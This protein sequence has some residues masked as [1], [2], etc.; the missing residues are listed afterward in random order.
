MNEIRR[1]MS[2][3]AAGEALTV[4]PEL[5]PSEL[6]IAR[7]RLRQRWELASVL[8]FLNV[9]EPVIESKMKTSAGDIEAALIKPDKLLSQ[10][11]IMLLKG[12]PPVSKSLKSSD[13]WVKELCKKLAKWWP[14]VAEGDNPLTAAKGEENSRY[15]ELDPTIRLSILKALCEIRAAQDDVV[16]YIND[17][18]KSGTELSYFRKDKIGGDGNRTAYWY[19]GNTIIG[20]RLYKEVNKYESNQKVKGKGTVPVMSSHWKTLATNLEEFH[21]VVDDFSSSED[22]VEVFVSKIIET[23]AIPVLE[24]L[25]KKK[26]KALRQQE[27]Q[28]TLLNGFRNSGITRSCRNRR[29]VSYTFDEYDKAIEEAIQVTKKRNRSSSETETD[30]GGSAANKSKSTGGDNLQGGDDD[31]DDDY[32]SDGNKD[33]GDDKHGSDSSNSNKENNNLGNRNHTTLDSREQI[34]NFDDK[35][36]GFGTRW[37][38]RLAGTTDHPVSDTR[39]AKNRLRQ[40][41]TR[42]TALENAVVFD[43]EDENSLENARNGMSSGQNSSAAADH[44]DD[45]DS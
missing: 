32:E 31:D 1:S 45:N 14:W 34:V 17:A 27:R 9:F 33:D 19:D 21:K 6:E 43:S 26:E 25:Q 28:E 44:S 13:A 16:R 36:F 24:K 42:N 35:P 11:H 37:S 18:I 5:S 23:D 41:P 22:K 7:R 29:P 4:A 39:G 2:T 38:L 3:V 8:N 20:Y 15:K 10:L 12:I 30:S 40:R